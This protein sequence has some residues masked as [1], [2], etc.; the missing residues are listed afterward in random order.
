MTD[1]TKGTT[2]KRVCELV[3]GDVITEVHGAHASDVFH[4]ENSG[5]I[6][7]GHGPMTVIKLEYSDQDNPN[8]KASKPWPGSPPPRFG[9]ASG[10]RQSDS[11]PA[12]SWPIWM[13]LRR[14][15]ERPVM[16]LAAQR[17]ASDS[18]PIGRK[19]ISAKCRCDAKLAANG[20]VQTLWA[21]WRSPY[22]SR[23]PAGRLRPG[24]QLSA[25]RDRA[26]S[27]AAVRASVLVSRLA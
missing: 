16:C 26:P 3:L 15:C 12:Q 25:A 20:E 21:S 7:G 1:P 10:A 8:S 14:D 13:H 22:C 24:H 5:A 23:Q 17:Y 4:I 6:V 18:M 2:S 27:R 11:Q 19:T 9:A